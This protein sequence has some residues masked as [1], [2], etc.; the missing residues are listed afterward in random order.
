[1]TYSFK[2]S[3]SK[4][5]IDT[6]QGLES[7]RFLC[8]IGLLFRGLDYLAHLTGILSSGDPISEGLESIF[9]S[10]LISDAK[11][12]E[13]LKSLWKTGPCSNGKLL[14]TCQHGV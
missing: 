11:E 2:T 8:Q 5:N 10:K 4:S 12:K 3:R 1:M 14:K 6:R 9:E 13:A 7:S